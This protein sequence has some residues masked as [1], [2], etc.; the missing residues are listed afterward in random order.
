MLKA[1]D[2]SKSLL[3]VRIQQLQNDA[4]IPELILVEEQFLRKKKTKQTQH[5]KTL[6]HHRL[7]GYKYQAIRIATGKNPKWFTKVQ[8]TLAELEHP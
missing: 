4:L 6:Y 5:I 2:F 8:Q 7:P 3:E 1:I